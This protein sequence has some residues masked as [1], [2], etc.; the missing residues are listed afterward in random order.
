MSSFK[1]SPDFIRIPFSAPL[2]V[3][4]I[5]ATGVA[6]PREQGQDIT[7][8]VMPAERQIQMMHHL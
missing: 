8:T 7:K 5:I 3:P 2:P 6:R 1:A 4:T